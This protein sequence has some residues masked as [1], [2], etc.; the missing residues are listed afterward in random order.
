MVSLELCRTAFIGDVV[1]EID[2]PAAE[3]LMS[4]ANTANVY[5]SA[6]ALPQPQSWSP[7]NS[8]GDTIFCSV[9]MILG[10]LFGSW[11]GLVTGKTK[12]RLEA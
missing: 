10:G 5:T 1:F 11:R 8:P 6:P 3:S 4:E 9:K 12:P 2:S 7:W